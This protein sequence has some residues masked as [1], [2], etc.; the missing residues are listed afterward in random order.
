MKKITRTF[1]VLTVLLGV[2]S[3]T[4]CGLFESV[5]EALEESHD[6]WFKYTGDTQIDIP[7]GSDADADEKSAAA[8]T[9]QDVELYLYF[10]ADEGLTVAVQSSYNQNVDVLGGLVTQTVTMYTGGTKTYTDF[11][12]LKWDTAYMN[13]QMNL[14]ECDEPEVSAHPEKCLILAGDDAKDCK[15]QWKKVLANILLQKL[16]EE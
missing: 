16:F 4:G 5:K 2:L 9:L 14:E 3:L 1:V 12:A 13:L 15:I 11:T 7:L 6:T 8:H 10:D